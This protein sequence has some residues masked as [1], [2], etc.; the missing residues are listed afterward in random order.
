MSLFSQ[1]ERLVSA[2]ETIASD[3]P[4]DAEKAAAERERADAEEKARKE[5]ARKA[6]EDAAKAKTAATLKKDTEALARIAALSS[7]QRSSWFWFYG[8]FAFA[9]FTLMGTTDADFF[10]FTAT[11]K[12]P[13]LN[14]DVNLLQFMTLS[15]VVLLVM[16]IY[17]HV[18]LELVWGDLAKVSPKIEGQPLSTFTPAWLLIEAALYV[19]SWRRKTPD[20][21]AIVS[22]TFLGKIGVLV[23]MILMW[24]GAPLTIGG[25][26]FRSFVLHDYGLSL[27]LGLVLLT[28]ILVSFWSLWRMIDSLGPQHAKAS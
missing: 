25:F 18:Q 9:A 24:G 2:V 8:I 22:R 20:E 11:T 5:A 19:R 21:D 28:A 23:T 13:V 27:R 12:L 1:F 15:P 10:K 4:T 16:H 6:V 14:Y 17:L 7:S 3:V 26:W